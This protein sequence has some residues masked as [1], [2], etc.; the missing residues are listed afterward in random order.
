VQKGGGLIV[1]F[2][3]I[4]IWT[5]NPRSSLMPQTGV[6]S[7]FPRRFLCG[8]LCGICAERRWCVCVWNFKI[9]YFFDRTPGQVLCSKLGL[10]QFPAGSYAEFC[11]EFVQ[12]G[13][14]VCVS[15]LFLLIFV[16]EPHV[17]S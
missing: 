11:A 12:K 10:C 7:L 8:I 15:F 9:G 16:T 14:G 3:L 5:P 13:G 4:K 17:G 2:F 1:D 6:R